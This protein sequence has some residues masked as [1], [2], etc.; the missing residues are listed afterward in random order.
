[1]PSSLRFIALLFGVAILAAAAAII[2][3]YRQN[4]R[5]ARITAERITGGGVDAGEVAMT[6]YGCGG[7]HSVS[8]VSGPQGAVGPA[9]GKFAGRATIAGRLAN[10]PDQLILWLRNPQHVVPGNAMPE[11]AMSDR[12]ARD[13]AAYL[14]TLR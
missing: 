7:C 8:P 3:Q 11:Q 10:K 13:L 1:M 12:D 4:E 14:Y 9:L 6:R 2:V 5:Q